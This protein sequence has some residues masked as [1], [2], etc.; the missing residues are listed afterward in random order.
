MPESSFQASPSALAL[1][2]DLGAYFRE[3][4]TLAMRDADVHASNATESYLVQLLSDFA[5]PTVD[6]TSPLS[7]SVTLLFRDAMNESGHERFKRLQHLGD[8]VLYA[9]GFFHGTHLRG[10]D[11]GYVAKIGSSAYGHAARMLRTGQG[12]A[13][14]PD[15]LDELA[16]QFTRFVD[17]LRHVSDWVAAKSARDE[18]SLLKLYDRYLKTGS[19]VLRDELTERGLIPVA[20]P[21][22]VH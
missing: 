7:Q 10:A 5:K 20:G 12:N 9:M 8:G 14:G 2:A 21:G 15:V 3:P 6:S 1:S 16:Q 11:Q 19:S 13:G 18:E 4:V 22:G 17:V